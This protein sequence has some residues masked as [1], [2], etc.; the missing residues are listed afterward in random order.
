M[1]YPLGIKPII[2]EDKSTIHPYKPNMKIKN[3]FGVA[4]IAT[5]LA[6]LAP[7]SAQPLPGVCDVLGNAPISA[8][9]VNSVAG[10]GAE[11]AAVASASFA[12]EI[13]AK[14]NAAGANLTEA[15]LTGNQTIGT[16]QVEVDGNTARTAIET[17][18][19]QP[20]ADTPAT[21][22]L[23]SALGGTESA[24]QLVKS[25]QGLKRSNG[26]I[27]PVVLTGAVNAYNLYVKDS[28]DRSQITQK[29]LSELDGFVKALPPGQK[30]AQVILT[31]LTDATR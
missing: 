5:A 3:I 29:P 4:A 7:V 28:I 20:G 24:A 16:M 25:M 31:K 22:A 18:T 14:V 2:I 19:S 30:V 21:T 9:T 26:S 11:S 12:P 23:V 15:S 1:P 27:D 17:I 10:G 6:P 8:D 13:Q